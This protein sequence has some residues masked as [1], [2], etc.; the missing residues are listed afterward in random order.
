MK[1]LALILAALGMAVSAFA[2]NV[3]S[4]LKPGERLSPFDVVDISGPDKGKQLC[5]V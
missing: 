2:A 1:K 5:I 4:G 3:E